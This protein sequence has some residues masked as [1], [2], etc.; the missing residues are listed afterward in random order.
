VYEERGKWAARL[1]HAYGRKMIGYSDEEVDAHALLDAAIEALAK[2]DLQKPA[3]NTLG[4]YGEAWLIRRRQMRS[5]ST[6]T[7]L[8]YKHIAPSSIAQIALPDLTRRHVRDWLAALATKRTH[9]NKRTLSRQTRI[10]LLNLVRGCLADALD[11]ELVRTNIAVGL[12]IAAVATTDPG[13]KYLIPDEQ[14]ALVQACSI[15]ERWIVETAL[16]TG[17][18]KGELWHLHLE[19]VHLDDLEPWLWIRF[20]GR[21]GST[22]QPPKNGKPRRVPL[23]PSAVTALRSWI[24]QLDTYTAT[25]KQKVARNP[26][27]LLFPGRFGEY[28][29]KSKQPASWKAAL[30][31]A[32]LSM[33][34]HDLRHT[35]ASSLVA[36]WWGR[37]WSIQ[38][39]ST[40]LGHSSIH[41]TE[42]YAHLAGSVLASAARETVLAIKL[43]APEG[44]EDPEP[45]NFSVGKTGF[46]PATSCSQSSRKRSK[47]KGIRADLAGSWQSCRDLPTR[48]CRGACRLPRRPG[49]C[50]A[51]ASRHRARR[52]RRLGDA[53]RARHARSSAGATWFSA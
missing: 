12:E 38:E 31:K 49:T 28:R 9:D 33:R 41:V 23:I 37:R 10:H 13:W 21:R 17:C 25:R 44:E 51:R 16:Y 45:P 8:W 34:W 26:H 22:L 6:Q 50:P 18:R 29:D 40:L 52:D 30:S 3:T 27:G 53:D 15:P 36:G 42:R 35:C 2:K 47:I 7:A 46:E 39:V 20:G 14:T 43:P 11:D 32:G 4:T 24:A 48:I 19:D 5:I 1:P